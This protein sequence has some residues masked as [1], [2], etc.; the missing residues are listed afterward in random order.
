MELNKIGYISAAG[1]A[2]VFVVAVV[3]FV[4]SP[5]QHNDRYNLAF[6]DTAG[7]ALHHEWRILPDRDGVQERVQ[8][9]IEEMM[10]GP[11]TLGA[12][13]FLPE[14][15]D[16]R[17]VV[18]DHADRT[19]YIDFDAA[20]FVETEDGRFPFVD[21]KHLIE[22]NLRHNIPQIDR[23]IVTVAGQLPEVPRFEGL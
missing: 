15:S 12:V 3:L 4:F 11:V 5:E 18:Y 10:L 13:P 9:L 22:T 23:I 2:T 21:L 6:P 8:L 7:G 16:L 1:A 17:S 14:R 19:I 20:F